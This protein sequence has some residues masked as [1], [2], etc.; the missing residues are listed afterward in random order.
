MAEHREHTL[1]GKRGLAAL[2]TMTLVVWLS[3]SVIAAE[4]ALQPWFACEINFWQRCAP[5]PAQRRAFAPGVTPAQLREPDEQAGLL[6]D[7]AKWGTPVVGPTGSISY[8]LPPQPVLHLFSQPSEESARSYLTWLKD[9]ARSREEAFAAIRRVATEMGYT[10]GQPSGLDVATDPSLPVGFPSAS[11]SPGPLLDATLAGG[12]PDGV[13]SDHGLSPLQH[14]SHF[15]SGSPPTVESTLTSTWS[16]AATSVGEDSAPHA[17]KSDMNGESGAPGRD[18]WIFYFFSPRC[19]YCAQET[20]IL[21]EVIRGRT[22]VVGIAMDTT[23]EELLEYV[24]KMKVTFPVTL[25]QGESKTFGITG[26]PVVVVQGE[27]GQAVRV[28]GLASRE[29]LLRALGGSR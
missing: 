23:R 1:R 7:L 12:F 21:N 14:T 11:P 16:T 19:P 8:Q 24:R 3:R 18:T 4:E 10:L 26:Y 22:D 17:V 29:E 5:V 9:K 27:N 28:N 15:P 25:D 6:R 20:P 2:M 13:Q